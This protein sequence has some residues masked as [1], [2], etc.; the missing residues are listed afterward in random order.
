ME[1]KRVR[2][3]Q[4]DGV[5]RVV[6]VALGVLFVM[7]GVMKLVVPMLASGGCCFLH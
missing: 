1:W 4:S 5:A 3:T 7:M 2:S 6:R